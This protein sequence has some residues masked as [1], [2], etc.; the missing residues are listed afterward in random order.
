MG[1]KNKF[2]KGL[3]KLWK[4]H[5]DNFL[6]IVEGERRR[7][8][9]REKREKKIQ[10]LSN[11][12]VETMIRNKKIRR[13]L[14]QTTE[15]IKRLEIPKGNLQKRFNRFFQRAIKKIR[16]RKF[17]YIFWGKEKKCLYVGKSAKGIRRLQG[18]RRSII[19]K[20]A[21]RVEIR[22]PVA[23]GLVK[24]ECM[25]IHILKPKY[26]EIKAAKTKYTRKCP[27]CKNTRRIKKEL[28]SVFAIKR[29]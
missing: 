21:R 25:A 4:Y 10:N 11:L 5:R 26:N 17:I 2:E 14:N 1:Y 22:V 18:Y 20:E 15:R 27:I 6:A 28:R 3:N 23:K 24:L 7:K 29:K 9:S 16:N 13:E 12:A 8:M 19:F